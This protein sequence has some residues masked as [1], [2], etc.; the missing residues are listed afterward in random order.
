ML[1][2]STSELMG[3][4]K[5]LAVHSY[6]YYRLKLFEA[7]VNLSADS[8]RMLILASLGLMALSFFAIA[9]A[10][11]LGTLLESY[12]LGFMAIGGIIMFITLLV[13]LFTKGNR[14]EDFVVKRLS[15]KFFDE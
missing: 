10:L 3:Q 12:S 6:Q 1:G 11:Y 5:Q 4:S 2:K 8:V 7:I 13:Y 9:G 14:V 15:N